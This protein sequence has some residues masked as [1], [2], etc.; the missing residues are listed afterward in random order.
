MEYLS[1][2]SERLAELLAEKEMKSEAFSQNAGLAGASVR[3]WLRGDSLPTLSSV[4][5]IADFFSCS[6]DFLIGRSET[7]ETIVPRPVPPFYPRLRAVMT[8]RRVTRYELTRKTSVKDPSFA[9]WAKGMLPSLPSV[10][11]LADYLH[12]SVDFLIG[13]SDF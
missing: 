6:V 11:I 1:K 8:A 13:R 9:N 7:E 5:K 2:F 4:V 3:S 12:V 10:C